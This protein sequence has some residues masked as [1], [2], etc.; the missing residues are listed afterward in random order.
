MKIQ[1]SDHFTYGRLLRFAAPSVAMMIFTS[2]YSVVDGFFVSN[3]AGKTPFAA[4]NMIWPVPM[5]L[6]AVGFMLGTGG[7]ALVS[8]TLGEGKK[9]HANKIFSFLVYVGII[10]GIILATIGILIIEPVAVL[11]GAE[12]EMISMCVTY[13][14]ILLFALPAFMLQNMF[15]SFMIAAEK[16]SFGLSITVIAGITNMIL[17]AL[18]MAVFRWGIVGAALA[19]MTSQFVGGLIPLVYFMCENRSPLRLVRTKF[20]GKALFKAC[21][22][23]SSELVT[24]ISMSFVAMLYN[25]QLMKIAGE[26]GVAAYGVIMY[27]SFIFIAIFLGY[28]IGMAPIISYHYGAGNFS[29]LKNVFQKSILLMA[30][31]GIVLT[32]CA[33]LLA[34]PLAK[35]YV[36]Y[37]RQLYEMTV[38]ALKIYA[39]SFLFCGF[40]IFGS[41]FFTALNNGIISAFISFLRTI[42]F[43]VAAVLIMPE[44]WGLEGIWYSV[45]TAEVLATAVSLF[46]IV[47][48]K[49]KYHY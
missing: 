17:D 45:M 34:V 20:D 32:V 42:V 41:A 38:H 19:T 33:Y 23:G 2:I 11:L 35:L 26:N 3:F 48:N 15:Q 1:L 31:A 12:G 16:P 7:T 49:K 6:G 44:I 27:V 28:A 39:M 36:G 14:R 13:G 43:Q 37:D 18:F 10:T 8:M 4:V 25:L 24:N 9:E 40:S 21:T 46:F 5:M 47:K 29:E 30:G 22:N